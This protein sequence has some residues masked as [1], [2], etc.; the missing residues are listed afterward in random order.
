MRPAIRLVATH[1][2]FFPEMASGKASRAGHPAA[3]CSISWSRLRRTQLPCR[4][5][6]GV[7]LLV[8]VTMCI[9]SGFGTWLLLQPTTLDGRFDSHYV[10]AWQAIRAAGAF[11]NPHY[12]LAVRRR[13]PSGVV[14]QFNP[15]HSLS[16]RPPSAKGNADTVSRPFDSSAFNFNR[17]PDSEVMAVFE[18][19][20]FTAGRAGPT[21]LRAVWWNGRP[22]AP[23][24]PQLSDESH[25]LFINASPLWLGHGLFVP[26]VRSGL[27]Q[28]CH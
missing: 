23:Q 21:L 11:R 26:A 27:A 18:P 14:V 4:P 28:V 6:R 25:A 9:A 24:P 20:T 15:T 7:C 16:K 5:T 1:E 17:V 2:S 3:S 10:T 12:D 13:L 8:A 19:I 22:D